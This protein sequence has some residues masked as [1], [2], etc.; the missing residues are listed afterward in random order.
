MQRLRLLRPRKPLAKAH[1][2]EPV[3]GGG[4]PC[5]EARGPIHRPWQLPVP[6]AGKLYL[7]RTPAM[8]VA[9]FGELSRWIADNRSSIGSRRPGT[10]W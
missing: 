5:S 4:R 1:F 10:I 3:V 6:V 7:F 2:C 9:P 8:W